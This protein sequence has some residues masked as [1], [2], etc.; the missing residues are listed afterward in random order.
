MT[1]T[2]ALLYVIGRGLRQMGQAPLVQLLAVVTTAVCMLLL[3]AVMLTWY[4]ARGV[5]GAWGVDVPITAYLVDGAPT[6]QVDDLAVRLASTPEVERVELVGPAE[7]MRRLADGLGGD[8]QLVAG[9]EPDILPASLEIHLRSGAP[10][11]VGPLLAERLAAFDVVDDVAVAGEW[12]AHAD[13]MLGTLGDVALGA[14]AL[15]AFACIAIIWTTIRL[16]VYARRTEIHILR[17]VGGSARFVRG[18]FI[19]EGLLQGAM[20][21]AVALGLL[22]VGFEAMRPFLERGLSMVFAAGALRF[23]TPVEIGFGVGFGALIG[24]LGSRAALGRHVET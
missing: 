19:F 17:L 6:E 10:G 20:G 22:F 7:A 11:E 16:A 24:V 8:A 9:I 15:V 5:A 18:P 2:R 13:A 1:S 4:N 21:A 12:V 3:G 14:A 23:F